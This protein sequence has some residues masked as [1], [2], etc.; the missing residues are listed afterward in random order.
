MS[1]FCRIVAMAMAISAGMSL[2][3]PRIA[4]AAYAKAVPPTLVDRGDGFVY[5]TV[6]NGWSHPITNLFGKV[7]GYGL[8]GLRGAMLINNPDQAGM[9]VSIG[10][11][12]PG[13][14]ALYR[15]KTPEGWTVFP[16]YAL[17]LVEENLFHK[18]DDR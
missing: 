8:R 4:E 14:Y 3:A 13:T 7:Y 15:F 6:Y 9:K 16:R 11:H 10:L 5:F 2:M 12:R 17:T 18:R 1:R